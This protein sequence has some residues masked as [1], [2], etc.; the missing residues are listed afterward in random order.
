MKQYLKT[1]IYIRMYVREYKENGSEREQILKC[2]FMQAHYASHYI[3]ALKLST[4]F[5][6]GRAHQRERYCLTI[7]PLTIDCALGKKEQENLNQPNVL[8]R[9]TLHDS[10]LNMKEIKDY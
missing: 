6:T 5:K 10:L 9:V 7:D 4:C 8:I 3:Q 2:S 1:H